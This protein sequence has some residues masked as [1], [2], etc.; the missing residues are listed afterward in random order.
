MEQD[1]VVV[2]LACRYANARDSGEF[3]RTLATGHSD[4]A[5]VGPDQWDRDRFFAPGDRNPGKINTKWL[6]KLAGARYFDNAFF[7]LSPREAVAIDPQ[8]RLLLEETWHCIEDSGLPIDLLQSGRTSVN[9]ALMAQD[10]L[11]KGISNNKQVDAFDPTGNYACIAANRISFLLNLNG[12]SRTVDTACS[13]SLVALAQGRADLLTEDCDFALVGGV[14]VVCSPWRY[15][16][17]SQSRMLSPDG[18][19]FTFDRRANGYVPG[20]GVGVV[21]LTTRAKAERLGCHIYGVLRGIATNHNGHNRSLT[22]PS[23]AA[24][25]DVINRALAAAGVEPSAVSYVEA[26]GTGTS[27]GDPIEIEALN[28]VYGRDRGTPLAVGSVKTNIGHVEAGAGMAG[29]IKVLLMLRHGRIAPTL[30]MEIHNPLLHAVGATIRFPNALVD[31]PAEHGPRTAGISSFGFGGVNCHAVVQEYEAPVGRR[32]VASP[33]TP[34]VFTLAAKTPEALRNTLAAWA[35]E[36]R[37]AEP[38]FVPQLCHAA[39]QRL[40]SQPYRLGVPAADI[41]DLLAAV[42]RGE[43]SSVRHVTA[44]PEPMV[45]LAP[46]DSSSATVCLATV[47]DS[48]A[49][50]ELRALIADRD[51][52]FAA[53]GRLTRFVAHL[54]GLAELTRRR[55]AIAEV[56]ALDAV[57]AAAALVHAQAIPMEEAVGA[58]LVDDP[59]VLQAP[60]RYTVLVGGECLLPNEIDADYLR[61]LVT[62]CASTLT[63]VTPYITQ[64]ALLLDHQHTFARALGRWEQLL[65][66]RSFSVVDAIRRFAEVAPELTPEQLAVLALAVN[67]AAGEIDRAWGLT[68]PGWL[69]PATAE[70]AVL[71]CDGIVDRSDAVSALFG[72]AELTALADTARSRAVVRSA[73]LTRF[74]ALTKRTEKTYAGR[75]LE[76]PAPGA[77]LAAATAALT[78]RCAAVVM[79]GPLDGESA[80]DVV[81][82]ADGEP[83]TMTAALLELWLRG[84]DVD[85]AGPQL[86]ETPRL[87]GLPGYVFDQHSFWHEDTDL[88]IDG[89]V[90]SVQPFIDDIERQVE[91]VGAPAVDGSSV[92]AASAGKVSTSP[93]RDATPSARHTLGPSAELAT[94]PSARQATDPSAR[95]I[96]VP[97]YRRTRE[98]DGDISAESLDSVPTHAGKTVAE[99]VPAVADATAVK[100]QLE[101]L[102]ITLVAEATRSPRESLHTATEFADIGIDSL[103]IHTLNLQL[104]ER[105]GDIAATL[106]FEC[107]TIGEVAGR[108]Q[109]D[110][111]DGVHKHFVSAL[112]PAPIPAP[113]PTLVPAP[114][115]AQSLTETPPAVAVSSAPAPGVAPSLPPA[116]A[117]PSSSP[118]AAPPALAEP[119]APASGVARA[120]GGALASAPS[121]PPTAESL[122]AAAPALA[123]PSAPGLAGTQSPTAEAAH[124]PLRA[125]AVTPA[126][127]STAPPAFAPPDALVSA[128]AAGVADEVAAGDVAPPAEQL[129][130]RQRVRRATAEDGIAVIG[131]DGRFPGA[132]SV[133]EFWRNLCDGV[134]SVAEIPLDRWDHAEY[135]DPQRNVPGKVYS[136]WGGFLSDVDLFDAAAFGIAPVEAAFM[137]P[138]ERLFLEATRGCLEVAGYSRERIAAEHDN[139]VGV[140]VGASFNNYQLV[141]HE[142]AGADSYVPINS[143]TYAVANRVSYLNDF[144]GP[145]LTLDT[146]CSSS[147][148]ALHL[149]CESLRRGECSLAVAGGVNLTLHPS[150]YQML[151]QYQFLSSDGRCRAFGA[152]GDGYVPAE[153]VGAFLLKPLAD[154]VCDGD[155]V[156]GVIQGSALT[157]GGR[158]NGFTVPSPA[159]HATAI[160]RALRQ[161][162]WTPDT[163]TCFEAHGTGTRLGDPVEIAA[164]RSAFET[165]T[166]RRRQCAIGS[167]KSNIGHAEAAAGVAQLAKV[168]LQ[169]QNRTLVPSLLH[170]ERTNP[171]IDFTNSPV[172]VQRTLEDWDPA[173]MGAG[174]TPRRAGLSSIGAG[175]TNVHVLIE[176]Y[177]R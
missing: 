65:A 92:I 93:I 13:A 157:H 46:H 177:Q 168:L 109:R 18:R 14:N 8:H 141:Q 80:L 47:S 155:R 114:A 87:P 77:D 66:A 147:L 107:R 169:L 42:R 35:V 104:S 7:N 38:E 124:T 140:Y 152:G 85:W 126:R 159:A 99:S 144:R 88:R 139:E 132:D 106:F 57:G 36:P 53:D 78:G 150:K 25:A 10:Y 3:W 160:E 143:Q 128:P 97:S 158:T 69:P 120:S 59:L 164:I 39:N 16:A 45:L 61:D 135:F 137:D 15:L 170:A 111:A 83:R 51:G 116:A 110:Y 49:G 21:L 71:I 121:L 44:Q 1:V 22:A 105:F 50:R 84:C 174:A 2:G 138:Q 43:L 148:Y 171:A 123:M 175:G 41:P 91:A 34:A 127:G 173:Q 167:V 81:Q 62:G 26:H 115:G 56:V 136:K 122:S 113:A 79:L 63:E 54:D 94:A 103:I 112:T 165:A 108:I 75:R 166:P 145:S 27:L 74:G 33:R 176:E 134:D 89:Q 161:A 90:P 17:F 142:A 37:W 156:Y 149:A 20:E 31:W 32:A 12:P 28:S 48:A 151:A 55:V 101:Q 153:A 162:R 102:L 82:I 40:L 64:A 146:A 6:G 130:V 100:A 23:V 76:L 5:E 95:Q 24:Q 9:V 67:V 58:L 133:P 52:E 30:N 117:S 131:F 72:V 70:L 163:I 86:D 119:S 125:P 73:R 4:I 68:P 118:S 129:V 19:C 98:S 11:I 96:A 172:Y 60:P 29:L 154:A